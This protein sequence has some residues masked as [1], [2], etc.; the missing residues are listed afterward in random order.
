MTLDEF[1]AG[2]SVQELIFDL[3]RTL[4]P[5]LRGQTTCEGVPPTFCFRKS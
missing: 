5:S 1:R 3:A 2:R 4:N